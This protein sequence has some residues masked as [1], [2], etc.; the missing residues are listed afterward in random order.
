MRLFARSFQVQ[1]LFAF[2]W[3]GESDAI[4]S[5]VPDNARYRQAQDKLEQLLGKP[6]SS[7]KHGNRRIMDFTSVSTLPDPSGYHHQSCIDN[8]THAR[9]K[10]DI[11]AKHAQV[12]SSASTQL[13]ESLLFERGSSHFLLVIEDHISYVI[14][15]DE[16][17]I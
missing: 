17:E 10:Q 7:S 3:M 16:L 6:R 12:G 11:A 8:S 2:Q 9:I 5:S 14:V 4:D 13:S 1:G 15:C